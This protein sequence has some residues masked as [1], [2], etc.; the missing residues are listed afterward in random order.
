MRDSFSSKS[1]PRRR[2]PSVA[3]RE[4][5]VFELDG[6]TFGVDARQVE[7]VIAWR[8]PVPLPRG[9]A[10]VLGVIQDRG[11]IVTVLRHPTGAGGDAP[12]AALLRIVV[13]STPRGHLGLPA[14]SARSV[15]SVEL[16]DEPHHCAVVEGS[17]GALTFLDAEALAAGIGVG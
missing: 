16:V 14:A 7:G 4:L 9:A 11:R 1:A 17:A 10:S 2:L 3:T 6:A 15:G 13:C 8:E 12:S 5:L